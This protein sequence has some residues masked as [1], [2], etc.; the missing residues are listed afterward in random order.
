MFLKTKNQKLLIMVLESP[1][2]QDYHSLYHI[3][4]FDSLQY[5]NVPCTLTVPNFFLIQS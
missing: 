5:P 4:C 2:D 3:K 1:Y